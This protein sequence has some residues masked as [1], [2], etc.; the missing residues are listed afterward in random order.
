[1]EIGSSVM[2]CSVCHF[3]LQTPMTRGPSIRKHLHSASLQT[4]PIGC[5]VGEAP[6]LEDQPEIP[7]GMGVAP[8]L[9]VSVDVAQKEDV[10]TT[11][12]KEGAHG[13]LEGAATLLAIASMSQ[14]NRA[15]LMNQ[16]EVKSSSEGLKWKLARWLLGDN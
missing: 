14:E 13:G 4:S 11:F 6:V 2:H 3:P 8:P 7:L 12:H 1:M 16:K 10:A 15:S 5:A 9:L